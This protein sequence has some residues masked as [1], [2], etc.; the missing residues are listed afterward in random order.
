L[1]KN[2]EAI[3]SCLILL[4]PE[5]EAKSV[6]LLRRRLLIRTS[7]LGPAPDPVAPLR[8]G[9]DKNLEATSSCHILLFPEK[10]AKSRRLLIRTSFLGPAPD[11][12][13]PLH[14]GF[15]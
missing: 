7:F 8:G 15:V 3:I 10:E 14:G 5:K 13:A 4:F 6:V 9:L 11:L 2:L 12:V 1:D